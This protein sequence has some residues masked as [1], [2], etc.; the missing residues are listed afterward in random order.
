MLGNHWKI[1]AFSMKSIK[2]IKQTPVDASGALAPMN[3][4]AWRV[5]GPVY[6]PWRTRLETSAFFKTCGLIIYRTLG[7]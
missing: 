7:W 6:I 5:P 3:K 2:I 1:L 4:L